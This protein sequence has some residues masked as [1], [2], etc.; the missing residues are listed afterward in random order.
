MRDFKTDRALLS[1]GDVNPDIIIPYG[2]TLAVTEA[3]R[4]GDTSKK[5]PG[6]E[7]R[8]GGSIGNCAAGIARLGGKSWF[9]GKAGDDAY[10][11]FLRDDF[12][13]IG[14]DTRYLAMDKSIH[15]MMVIAVVGADRERVLYALPKEHGSHLKL[16]R[17]DLPDAMLD[18][19]GWVHTSGIM[20][21]E[22]PAGDAVVNFL[23]RAR[24]HGVT[25]SF[26]LNMRLEAMTLSGLYREYIDRAVESCH[27]L[28]GNGLE[29]LCP[30]TGE[31]DPER[32][33]MAL[34][35]GGRIVVCRLGKYGSKI[36]TE[37]GELCS[38]GAFDVEV[39]DTIGAGDAFNA[40]FITAAAKGLPLETANI[41][42]NAAACHNLI[43][44][45]ARNC[46]TPEQLENFLEEYDGRFV[47]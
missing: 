32:A 33:S 40:G 44:E 1:L 13:S 2:E 41:H 4:R 36:Y 18:E 47:Q 17:D 25:V 9:A 38:C 15:T 10:G 6:A 5:R 8:P 45:G 21:R 24:A 42:G 16:T 20:L 43:Y 22:D 19:I 12:E 37:G 29:E 35:R 26:D 23:E 3:V 11:S 34:A 46:P 31:S 7:L 39:R 27:I 28:F 14:V 30:L